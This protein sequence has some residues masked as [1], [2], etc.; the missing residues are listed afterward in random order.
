M[1]TSD[2]A[3]RVPLFVQRHWPLALIVA[4]FGGFWIKGLWNRNR[5]K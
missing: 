2:K 3:T 5:E 1:K 4:L